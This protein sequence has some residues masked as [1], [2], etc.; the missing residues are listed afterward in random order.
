MRR[1]SFSYVCRTLTT[2]T[3]KG[4]FDGDAFGR[5]LERFIAPQIG[6]YVASSGSGLGQALSNDDLLQVYRVAVEV[7]KGKIPVGANIPEQY[8]SPLS[9][10]HAR[11]AAKAG[12]DIIN[13]Y[14]PDG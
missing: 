13:I 2:F 3:S 1:Q 9:I 4:A 12:V 10:E 6:V 7:G 5:F 11:L 8:T 14:G